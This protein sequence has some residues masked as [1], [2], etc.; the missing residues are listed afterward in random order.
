MAN[1]TIDGK[2]YKEEE[3]S[4]DALVQVNMLRI[5]DSE[6]KRIE[7]QLAIAKTARNAYGES[8]SKNLPNK[9]APKSR[10]KDVVVINEKRYLYEDM[11][12][13]AVKDALSIG[14]VDKRISQLESELAITKTAKSA[15]GFALENAMK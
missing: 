12:E 11:N 3:L 4:K 2:E 15:Y 7:G 10:K 1:I 6:I 14:F 8:L 5:V 9:E 13:K